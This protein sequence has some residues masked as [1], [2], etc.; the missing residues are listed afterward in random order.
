MARFST[1][2][3]NNALNGL[4]PS[5]STFYLALFSSDP[6]TTGTTGE[7]TSYTGSRPAFQFN[8]ATG[9]TQ[10][11]PTSVINFSVT[12]TLASGAPYFGIFTAATG[13]TYLVGGATTGLTGSIA[14][15]ATI[16]FAANTSL[17]NTL[18]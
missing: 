6:G 18:A 5:T 10:T 4:F 7:I 8:A 14:S 15:G 13:G 16:T 2:G 12:A 3:I 11:G 1:T 17:T 9:G